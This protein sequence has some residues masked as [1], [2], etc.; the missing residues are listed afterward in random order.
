M[1]GFSKLVLAVLTGASLS[2]GCGKRMY[3]SEDFSRAVVGADIIPLGNFEFQ[4]VDS[5]GQ[6][7]ALYQAGPGGALLYVFPG[8]EG[9]VH[10]AR[11]GIEQI[12]SPEL[13][14][15]VSKARTAIQ[16]VGY[17]VAKDNGNLEK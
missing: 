1:K 13:R 7:D 16:E 5:D 14:V 11:L 6:V 3:E 17:Q 15:L 12:M 4:D 8:Y 9:K 2:T 10:G